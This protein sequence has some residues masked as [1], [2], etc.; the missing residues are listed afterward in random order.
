MA[1]Y[2]ALMALISNHAQDCYPVVQ[3]LSL[4]VLHNLQSS[5]GIKVDSADEDDVHHYTE[6][7]A[8]L[9]ATMAVRTSLHKN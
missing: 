4:A 5:V 7:Q 3:Q 6:S 2:E 9:C 8:L 1:V